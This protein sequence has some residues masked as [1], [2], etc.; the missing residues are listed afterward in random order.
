MTK[1]EIILETLCYARRYA[2]NRASFAPSVVNEAIDAALGYGIKIQPDSDPE[3]G[4]Y[5]RDY[6]LGKWNPKRQKFEGEKD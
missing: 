5:A 4:M 2:H 1:D 6:H 3:I